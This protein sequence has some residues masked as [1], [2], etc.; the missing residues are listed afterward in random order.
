MVS[1][2]DAA[3][4]VGTNVRQIETWVRAGR[5]IGLVAQDGHLKLPRW[6]FDTAIWPLLPGISRALGTRDGWV[7]LS[8]LETPH[9]ALDGLTPRSALEQDLSSV[10]KDCLG[11]AQLQRSS[12]EW[13]PRGARACRRGERVVLALAAAAAHR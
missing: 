5:C 1:A 11:A 10:G 4:L 12:A 13:R 9:P 2:G 6:Q 7:T 8:F 3:H